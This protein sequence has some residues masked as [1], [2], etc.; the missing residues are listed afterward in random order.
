MGLF[1]LRTLCD[2]D[3]PSTRLIATISREGPA[4]DEYFIYFNGL[5]KRRKM[6]GSSEAKRRLSLQT[7]Y[8]MGVWG[9]VGGGGG[10]VQ[11]RPAPY[12]FGGRRE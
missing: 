10:G 7:M 8:V 4:F 5:R 2:S 12:L 3:A 1:L 6:S 11:T 9:W